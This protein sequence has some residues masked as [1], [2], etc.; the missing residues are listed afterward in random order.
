MTEAK[1]QVI[2]GPTKGKG[3]A[4]I[5]EAGAQASV[6]QGAVSNAD[7]DQVAAQQAQST[8]LAVA[9]P[10]DPLLAALL[11]PSLDAEKMKVLWD[12]K[13]EI[14]AD[15]ARKAFN[16]DYVRMKPHLPRII[17]THNNQQTSSKYAKL[18]DINE[19]VD[20]ILERF[21]FGSS[22]E[23]V[24]NDEK[25]ISGIA[26]LI[27]AQGHIKKCPI[28]MPIDNKGMQGTVNKT[29]PHGTSSA[30][31]YCRRV[32]KCALLDISTG[33]DK[34]GNQDTDANAF[35][36]PEQVEMLQ[37]LITET[38]AGLAK[39]LKLFKAE[40]IETIK[41]KDFSDAL[42][43]LQERKKQKET[44]PEKKA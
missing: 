25:G 7:M 3:H 39:F 32:S 38:K 9:P 12:M 34:D 37:T 31:M 1:E 19:V 33:D 24:S 36:T 6:D 21:N 29:G 8:S 22:F 28:W 26:E 41:G 40:T 15:N 10:S 16:A 11:N 20:P 23:I 18:E 35:I 27:H 2:S 44:P 14:D 42:A 13:K 17:K 4:D 5:L 30:I 43:V